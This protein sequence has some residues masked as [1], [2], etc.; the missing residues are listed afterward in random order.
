MFL[1]DFEKAYDKISWTFLHE[2]MRKLGFLNLW[3][4]W[5]TFLYKEAKTTMVV[6]GEKGEALMKKVHQ[7]CFLTPYLYLFVTD[8]LGYMISN[9]A[10]G[11]EGLTLP[12]GKQVHIKCL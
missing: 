7:R 2:C 3:R 5:T 12:N 6:N 11:I 9:P 4:C 1:L 8:V 10:Y